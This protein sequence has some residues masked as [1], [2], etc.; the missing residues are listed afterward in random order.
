MGDSI[1]T[2]KV[3]CRFHNLSFMTTKPRNGACA[4]PTT[5]YTA[6]VIANAYTKRGI[7][8]DH[9]SR[10]EMM[11]LFVYYPENILA[12]YEEGLSQIRNKMYT[13]LEI[14]YGVLT[15]ERT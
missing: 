15:R 5:P 8:V 4:D 10:R 3:A 12:C 2:V 14:V 6:L 7:I 11:D 13:P 9:C 1:E